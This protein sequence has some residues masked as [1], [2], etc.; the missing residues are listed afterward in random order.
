MPV[1]PGVFLGVSTFPGHVLPGSPTG[2]ENAQIKVQRRKNDGVT[3][4]KGLGVGG[5]GMVT[6]SE[7]C[8]EER[9]KRKLC[10]HKSQ[11]ERGP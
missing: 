6:V 5:G 1:S 8:L 10:I 4:G 7:V 11:K 2:S 3:D 9:R